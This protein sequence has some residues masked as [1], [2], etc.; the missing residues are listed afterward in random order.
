MLKGAAQ[1]AWKRFT[2]AHI[3][4]YRLT[5][6]RIGGTFRGVDTLLL[7]H[8][9]RRSG[10]RRTNPLY[11]VADGDDLV[12]VASRGGSH[13]HPAW[14]LNLRENPR[15]TVQVGA[16]RREVVAREATDAERDRLWPRLVEAW[17]DY[18]AY[19]RRTKRR[20]PVI[21]LSPA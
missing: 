10:K 15:T 2:D 11:Y 1:F 13:K 3:A 21:V 8:V 14:W 20:I 12:I 17:P 19:Q 6:G 16:D 4:A 5:G 9:G 7:D 18:A